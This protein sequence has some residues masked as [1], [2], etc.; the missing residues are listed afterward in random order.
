[1]CDFSHLPQYNDMNHSR[2]RSSNPVYTEGFQFYCFLKTVE[3][4]FGL[5][6]YMLSYLESLH[7]LNQIICSFSSPQKEQHFEFTMKQ[8][9]YRQIVSSGGW[10]FKSE[11]FSHL[12]YLIELMVW[13]YDQLNNLVAK[14]IITYF[15]SYPNNDPYIFS[16]IS[17]YL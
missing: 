11:C 17:N 9:S 12:I 6:F 7:L 8:K 2:E 16:F 5:S 4:N 3:C 13:F 1:M 15:L 10:L 14:V